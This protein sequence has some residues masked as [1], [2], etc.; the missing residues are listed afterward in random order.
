M[1]DI[2]VIIPH[3]IMPENDKALLLNIN[4]LM[5]N[6]CSVLEIIID[7]TL[8]DPYVIYNESAKIARSNIIVFTNSDV[9]MAPDWDRPFIDHMQDNAILTGYLVEPGNVGVALENIDK[10]FGKTPDTFDRNAFESFAMGSDKPAIK[11]QRGWY[12]P[13]AFKRDWFIGTGGFDTSVPFPHPSDIAFWNKCVRELGTKL[14]RVN[15]FAYHFQA[16]SH[17]GY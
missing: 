13:C 12:M 6:S 11:E 4:A 5:Q 3:K 15:S 7:T 9:I 10:D 2:T 8:G 17:R 14:L 1:A 16:L